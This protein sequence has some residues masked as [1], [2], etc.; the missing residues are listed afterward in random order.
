MPLSLLIAKIILLV[1]VSAMLL[2]LA[3]V[4]IT[5]LINFPVFLGSFIAT[6]VVMWAIGRYI[7]G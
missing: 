2:A 5:V 7:E 3:Y 1:S 4:F 6:L